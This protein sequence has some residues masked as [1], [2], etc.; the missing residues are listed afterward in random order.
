G[1]IQPI[2]EYGL[3]FQTKIF[4]QVLDV[5]VDTNQQILQGLQ[6]NHWNVIFYSFYIAVILISIFLF[7][8]IRAQFKFIKLNSDLRRDKTIISV[9]SHDIA[10]PLTLLIESAKRLKDKLGGQYESEIERIL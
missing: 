10:T 1:Q 2:E 8:I 9:L 4:N 7:Y 5:A 6:R 3:R